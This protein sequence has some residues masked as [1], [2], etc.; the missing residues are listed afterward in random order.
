MLGTTHWVVMLGFGLF[1]IHFGRRWRIVLMAGG[2]KMMPLFGVN[3]LF[4]A[5]K[6]LDSRRGPLP[7]DF[8]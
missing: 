1:A 6:R 8:A 7:P 3:P 4:L 5:A 2:V